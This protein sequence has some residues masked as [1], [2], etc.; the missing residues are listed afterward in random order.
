MAPNT[1][2]PSSVNT[3]STSPYVEGCY[4]PRRGVGLGVAALEVDSVLFE[5]LKPASNFRELTVRLAGTAPANATWAA[6][7]TTLPAWMSLVPSSGVYHLPQNEGPIT[8]LTANTVGVPMRI[9]PYTINLRFVITTDVPVEI[10][11]PIIVTG[12]DTY[13]A[14]NITFPCVL[15]KHCLR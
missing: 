4:T 10:I 14:C 12:N 7:A 2:K 15:C 13:H 3:A 6:D 1:P 5:L 11:M 9:Q 8:L